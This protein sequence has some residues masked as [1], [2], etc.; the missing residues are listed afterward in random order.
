[1]PKMK[2]KS[3]SGA[4]KRIRR[5]GSG[6]LV[7]HKAGKRHLLTSKHRARK[8]RLKGIVAV[9]RTVTLTIN[10]LLPHT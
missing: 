2:L 3:H 8:R 10:R 5:T 1:M 7:R 6:R 9:D 4:S